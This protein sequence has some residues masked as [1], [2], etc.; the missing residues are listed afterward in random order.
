LTEKYSIK[1]L[2]EG[3]KS[4]N[5][6]ILRYIY[7]D[8]FPPIEKF[9]YNN[10]GTSQDARDVFHDAI[11]IIYQK[12]KE[13]ELNI[14]CSLKNYIFGIC[15]LIW[16]KELKAA[17][18]KKT[19][20]MDLENTFSDQEIEDIE[21]REKKAL[22]QYHFKQLSEDCQKMLRLFYDGASMEEISEIMGYRSE[23]YTRRKKFDCKERLM[24]M[25]KDDPRYNN[26]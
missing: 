20:R 3:I 4:R 10:H 16:L 8:Y 25:I 6:E 2:L 13:D 15:K 22:F 12:L 7:S 1:T 5:D 24:K 14:N 18:S 26:N 9:I 11:L 21:D 23:G 17:G 19:F